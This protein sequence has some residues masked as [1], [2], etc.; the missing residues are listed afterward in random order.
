ETLA[1]VFGYARTQVGV[2]IG[3]RSELARAELVTG[4]AFEVLSVEP[5]RGRTF[6]PGADRPGGAA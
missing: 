4:T 3:D 5:H 1:G 2:R 6:G